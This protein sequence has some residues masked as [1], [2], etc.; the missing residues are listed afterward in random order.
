MIIFIQ[1]L[2][3][4]YKFEWDLIKTRTNTNLAFEV[5]EVEVIVGGKVDDETV[6]P[7]RLGLAKTSCRCRRDVKGLAGGQV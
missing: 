1:I 4:S 7:R 6:L 5:I 2:G 3:L